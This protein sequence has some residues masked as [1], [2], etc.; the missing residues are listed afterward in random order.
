MNK[1]QTFLAAASALVLLIVASACGGKNAEAV[2]EENRMVLDAQ[3]TTVVLNLVRT[4]MQ[5]VADKDFDAAAALLYT[6][7]YHDADREPYPLTAEQRKALDEMYKLPVKRFEVVDYVFE[8]PENN[9]VQCR[10]YFTDKAYTNWYFK[11]VRY[12]GDWFLCMKD[13]SQGDRNLGSKVVTIAG[14]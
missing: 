5:R 12:L 1:K 3:D 2:P 7:D 6:V 11:P 13:S 10:V 8:T 9:E 4:Y 14:D